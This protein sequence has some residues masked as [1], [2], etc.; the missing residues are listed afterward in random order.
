MRAGLQ[1]LIQQ[2]LCFLIMQLKDVVV[3]FLEDWVK[4]IM[5]RAGRAATKEKKEPVAEKKKAPAPAPTVSNQETKK[6]QQL[7]SKL[8]EQ[9][10]ALEKE[11]TRAEE[12]LAKPEIYSNPDKLVKASMEFD[13]VDKELNRVQTEWEASVEKLEQ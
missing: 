6:L 8:E 13:K 9:I 10:T 7:I 5:L 3:S 1:L 2:Y 12:E 11:K 4:V